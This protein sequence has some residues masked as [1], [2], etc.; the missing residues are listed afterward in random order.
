[1]Q[2]LASNCISSSTLYIICT[3]VCF[4]IRFSLVFELS[5]LH[6]NNY[7]WNKDWVIVELDHAVVAIK[8]TVSWLMTCDAEVDWHYIP[9]HVAN[10]HLT[11]IQQK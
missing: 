10:M 1:M 8:D 2:M 9:V 11:K 7:S 5:Y 6:I 3:V 4:E